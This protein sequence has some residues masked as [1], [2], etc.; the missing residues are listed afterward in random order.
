EWSST[1]ESSGVL[2][3]RSGADPEHDAKID[4]PWLSGRRILAL[5]IAADAT[6][7]V[8]LSA[9]TG[10]A[11]LD[12]CAVRR[13]E[14]GVPSALTEPI[15]M[16]PA[17]EDVTPAS[18]YDEVAVLVLGEQ[19]AQIVDFASDRDPLPPLKTPTE[20]IAGTV[21]ADTIWASTSDGTLLRSDGDAWTTVD[22][23]ATDP[24]FY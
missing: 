17:L 11:R 16:R 9:D 8:V 22:V 3:A 14:N 6:R 20:R 4:A 2:V 24:W 15:A 10:G 5:H 21:V 7:M 19:R 18:W 12:L 23:D 1:R 13:D